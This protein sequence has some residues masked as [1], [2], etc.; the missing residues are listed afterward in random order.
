MPDVFRLALYAAIFALISCQPSAL[1]EAPRAVEPISA[2]LNSAIQAQ[3]REEEADWMPIAQWYHKHADQVAKARL[4]EAE[5]VFL[6]DSITASWHRGKPQEAVLQR[7]F[8][9]YRTANFAIGG[10]QTQHL[11]WRLQNGLAGEL[12]PKVVVIMIGVNNFGHSNHNPEQ[13]YQGV[14]AVVDQAHQNY[15][16]A[17]LIV[18]GILP[19]D[20]HADSPN[21]VKVTQTN[22]L[23]EQLDN[24]E[25]VSV[26]NFGDLFLDPNAEIPATLMAD[27][28]HPTPD[29]LELYAQHLAPLVKAHIDQYNQINPYIPAGDEQI[30]IMGRSATGTNHE[31]II[32]YPG[33]TI[34]MTVNAKTLTML[35]AS[36]GETYFDLIID[37]QFVRTI[38]IPELKRAVTLFEHPEAQTHSVKLIN[39][40]ETW[41]GISTL[42]GFQLLGGELLQSE[43]LAQRK[44]LVIGDSI[45]C[46]EAI[47]RVETPGEVCQKDMRWWNATASFGMLLG[48]SLNA[49]THLVCYGG[50]GVLRS[51]NGRT[52]ELNAED[53][54]HL[55]VAE[56]T[57]QYPWKQS[58]YQADLVLLSIGSNDFSET[59]GP[60]PKASTYIKAY[61]QLVATLLQD[62]PTAKLVLTEGALLDDS[63]P[64]RMAKS[65]LQ[66][67][68]YQVQKL[69]KSDRVYVVPSRKYQ[70]DA[71]DAHPTKQEHANMAEDFE[72]PLRNI[73]GWS[74]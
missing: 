30:H 48:K 49:Q 34:A 72:Q 43:P 59:A 16:N 46:G 28:L 18:N 8:G 47:D 51:W 40:S 9:A 73:M 55:A 62:H 54:Y 6:G 26:V 69:S 61:S 65:T 33:V 38:Q 2:P 70:G 4:G 32:G 25:Y 1:K 24:R 20:Q 21:R 5:L 11:L 45:A 42:H 3:P 19:F 31:R 27:Y 15:P 52:D 29:G 67:Y 58:Q 41:H 44:L 12:D 63:N 64:E 39:R 37:G 23:I 68:L 71:C 56:N 60:F 35:S 36:S 74:D 13:V 53:F 57:K 10:D 7:Y 17:T 14:S 22:Q 66:N 50:R